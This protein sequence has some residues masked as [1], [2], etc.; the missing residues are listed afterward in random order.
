MESDPGSNGLTQG[1][2]EQASASSIQSSPNI[3]MQ[4]EKMSKYFAH[5]LCTIVCHE[6]E[7]SPDGLVQDCSISIANALEILQYCTRPSH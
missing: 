5:K 3:M 7:P 1:E 6:N 2:E 4:T